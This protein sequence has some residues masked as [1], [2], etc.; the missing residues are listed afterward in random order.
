MLKDRENILSALREKPLK[1]YQLMRRANLP[2]EEACQS[3]LLK[4]R[5]EGLVKFDIHKGLWLIG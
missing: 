5:D 3:L 2:N 4:M 1:A